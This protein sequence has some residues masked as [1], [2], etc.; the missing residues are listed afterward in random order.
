MLAE[1]KKK[2]R[3]KVRWRRLSPYT[4]YPTA[5]APFVKD[6]YAHKEELTLVTGK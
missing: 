5:R 4:V 3:K 2:K 6:L 1:K